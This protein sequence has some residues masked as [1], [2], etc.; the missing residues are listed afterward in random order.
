VWQ[1]QGKLA[2]GMASHEAHPP[3]LARQIGGGGRGEQAAQWSVAV[4]STG[5][6]STAMRRASRQRGGEGR[7]QAGSMVDAVARD[8]QHSG[9]GQE[10][11]RARWRIL[12]FQQGADKRE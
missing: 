5:A 4:V 1:R 9:G 7:A 10:Q 12:F 6:A 8:Q 3:S 11:E 2:D